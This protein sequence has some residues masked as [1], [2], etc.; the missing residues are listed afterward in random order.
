[1]ML[2]PP[3]V[4]ENGESPGAWWPDHALLPPALPYW[5]KV[6]AQVLRWIVRDIR[7]VT[8]HDDGTWPKPILMGNYNARIEKIS[9]PV[10][11]QR[12][13]L[14]EAEL[15]SSYVVPIMEAYSLLTAWDV[16]N[17][18]HWLTKHMAFDWKETS[19][20]SMSLR[21]LVLHEILDRSYHALNYPGYAYPQPNDPDVEAEFSRRGHPYPNTEDVP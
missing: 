9:D 6:R 20:R 2:S 15:P 18:L 5:D 12:A 3:Y 10:L 7:A 8:S 19:L 16:G 13:P 4:P 17:I 21:G 1:M 14:F 11:L